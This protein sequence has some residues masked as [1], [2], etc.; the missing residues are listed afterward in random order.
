MVLVRGRRRR[1]LAAAGV[2]GDGMGSAGVAAALAALAGMLVIEWLWV[3]APQQVP[4]S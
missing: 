1:T 3:M 4:L 2:A